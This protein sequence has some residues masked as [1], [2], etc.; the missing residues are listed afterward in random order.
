MVKQQSRSLFQRTIKHPISTILIGTLTVILATLLVKELISKPILS[1]LF[2]VEPTIKAITA[3][4]GSIAMFLAYRLHLNYFEKKSFSE[5]SFKHVHK[6]FPIGLMI[7]F[8]AM[9]MVVFILYLLGYYHLVA[10]KSFYE[11]LPTIAFIFGA[12]V[13]EEIIF[14][15]LIFRLLE[16][17]KG[18]IIALLASS[19]VF[20]LP[21][22]M[23]LHTG[24][25]PAI[26]G[27]LFGV[28]TG[29]M[30]AYTRRLWLPIA[31]HFSWNLVQP[32]FITTLSG[33]KFISLFEGELAGPEL[34]IGSEFGL[35][36]SLFSFGFLLIIGLYYYAK[37]KSKG[38]FKQH[39]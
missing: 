29:L 22:F 31:F 19:L 28:V 14:R 17:W 7:G 5:F 35:E 38:Y 13:L 26:L 21:H 24:I 15:G 37:L 27:V 2:S 10:I 8:G 3:T 36:V 4:I 18:P 9:G 33:G 20:Q 32:I 25:S 34:L 6:E 30:Y 12:A 11:F 1:S 16:N 39:N 23:N